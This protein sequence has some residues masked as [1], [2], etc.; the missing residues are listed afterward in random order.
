MARGYA[1]RSGL[2]QA[3]TDGTSRYFGASK[4]RISQRVELLS[5]LPPDAELYRAQ[6]IRWLVIHPMYPPLDNLANTLIMKGEAAQR[7][8]FSEVRVVEI[9]TEP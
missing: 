4:D 6:G 5:E 8:L 1:Q 3:W 2:G 9:L 7:R